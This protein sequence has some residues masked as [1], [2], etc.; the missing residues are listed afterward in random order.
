MNDWSTL[1]AAVMA[2]MIQQNAVQLQEKNKR[3][4]EEE[5]EKVGDSQLLKPRNM[6][7][8]GGQKQIRKRNN[9]KQNKIDPVVLVPTKI[10]EAPLRRMDRC[11]QSLII[12]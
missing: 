3:R 9:K 4:V 11:E 6:K 7:R 2:M 5:R 12:S 8:A 10:E 1:S